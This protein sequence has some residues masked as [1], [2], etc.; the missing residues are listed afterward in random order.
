MKCPVLV[1]SFLLTSVVATSQ[2]EGARIS[3]RVTDPTDAVIVGAACEITNIETNVSITA[4][5]NKDGIYVIPDLRP[6]IYR[7]TIKKEGFRTDSQPNLRLYV[8]DAVNENFTLAVGSTSEVSV[9][10]AAE[11]LLQT[12]SAVVSTVVDQQFVQ[13]MPLNGRSFQSLIELT[14][15]VVITPESTGQFSVNGQRTDANYF[16]VDGVSANF[17]TNTGLNSAGVTFGGTLPALTSG[18]GTNGLLSVDAMQ[19]F[20]IQTSSFA[21]EFGRSPGAQISIV[22][23]GGT[24]HWHGTAFDY[25]RNDIFDARNY[26]DSVP[27]P[28]PPVRQNDFGGTFGG[29]VWKNHTFFFFSYESLRLRLPQIETGNYFLD[30]AAKASVPGTDPWQPAIAAFP[31]GPAP[32]PDGSNLLDPTCDNVTKPC[33]TALTAAYSNPSTL[34]AY[35]LRL[36]HQLANKITLFVRY[37]HAPSSDS[38]LFFNNNSVVWENNDTATAGLTA[39]VSPTLV[40]DFRGNW[41]RNISGQSQSLQNTYGAVVPPAPSLV[42]P[43]IN[44]GSFDLTYFMGLPGNFQEI[45]EGLFSSAKES[46]F[47]FVDTLSKA[48][49]SHQLKFGVDYRRLK[50]TEL[51]SSVVSMASYSWTS[52]LQGTVGL[53]QNQTADTITAH[54]SNWSLFGQDTWK[55]TRRLTLTYGMRWEISTPP[56]SDTPGKPIYALDGI[57]NSGPLA[58]VNRPLWNTDYSAFAPRVGSAFQVNPTTVLRSGFG[59]FYDLG[60]G[61]GTGNALGAFYPYVRGITDSGVPLAFS[62]RNAQGNNPYQPIPFP[63]PLQLNA[64]D[65]GLF[66]TAVDPNLRLPVTYQWNAAIERALGNQQSIT[67]TYVGANGRQLLFDQPLAIPQFSFFKAELNAGISHYNALQLQFMRRMSHGLQALLSYSYSRS[68][69]TASAEN[70][71]Q[72]FLPTTGID[73]IKLP[74]LDSVR[75]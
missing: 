71:P 41:S 68:N 25:L 69:D 61:G 51:A 46:Q 26:F 23:K 62:Y 19:E 35:S 57:F 53:L 30:A 60:Y 38:V 15:G 29:P 24:N 2:T 75:L 59:M 28:K 17:R 5:T 50:P 12:D 56:V 3:G 64:S 39:S 32:L 1:V 73:T 66:V 58:L 44:T 54:L 27:L 21:P 8:Q 36:D 40:N 70:Y 37:N 14:P 11:P 22:T 33:Q 74:P 4:I 18:G 34:S 13:N 10:L 49:G 16:T 67:A 42:P 6:A 31:T 48:V 52:F 7:L 55:A 63:N 43:D 65:A 45:D 9:V 72:A 47:N 20:R